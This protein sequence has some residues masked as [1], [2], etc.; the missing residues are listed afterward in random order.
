MQN[1][2]KLIAT[3]LIL[4]TLTGTANAATYYVSPT[5]N[6]THDGNSQANT[7]SL[8]EAQE[9]ANAKP[10]EEIIFLLASGEYGAFSDSTNERTSWAIWKADIGEEP[11]FEYISLGSFLGDSNKYLHFEG[12]KVT[13]G[14]LHPMHGYY[15]TASIRKANHIKFIDME[16]EGNGYSGGDDSAAIY[17]WGG[18]NIVIDDCNIY[19]NDSEF[20]SAFE[21]GIFARYVN[22][23]VINNCSI[24]GTQHGISAWGKNWTITNNHLYNLDSD[25]IIV[26]GISDSNIENNRIHDVRIPPDSDYHTDGIQFY[27]TKMGNAHQPSNQEHV[28]MKNIVVRNNTIYNIGRQ[29]IFMNFGGYDG[30]SPDAQNI[31]IENNLIYDCDMEEIGSYSFVSYNNANQSFV[32]NTILGS[33]HW[34]EGSEVSK[35]EGNLLE[36]GKFWDNVPLP[37]YNN[38]NL[39][40]DWWGNITKGSNSIETRW[41]WDD[42]SDKTLWKEIFTDYENDDYNPSIGKAACDG[43][44]NG[45][46]GVAIGALPCPEE[47]PQECVDLT[48]LTNYLSEWKLGNLGM[49]TLLEK[50]SSW[51]TGTG[52]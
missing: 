47:P 42:N 26:Q 3:A 43:S 15:R 48:S 34:R 45:Q 25:G 37:S 40:W 30:T 16:F 18:D 9:Y 38:Y 19:G 32:N 50:I 36:L 23:V 6:N 24:T 41:D 46:E 27:Y 2:F 1:K 17:M 10:S 35:I 20:E 29:G 13:P 8:S 28:Y 4:L 22:N 14:A 31:T 33:S 51:K 11:V 49:T 39:L 5:G 44:V 52:C 12:I 7:F 21:N